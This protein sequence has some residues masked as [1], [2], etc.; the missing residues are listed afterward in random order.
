M[1]AKICA[2]HSV[3]SA[4]LVEDDDDLHLLCFLQKRHGVGDCTRGGTAAIPAHHN[5]IDLHAPLLDEG[6]ENHRTAGFKQHPFINDF[7]GQRIVTVRLADNHQVEAA[8]DAA[9]LVGG[10]GNAGRYGA[11]LR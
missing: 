4:W 7:V 3:T 9:D 8:A 10:S 5:A 6:Y 11:G 1:L 2:G